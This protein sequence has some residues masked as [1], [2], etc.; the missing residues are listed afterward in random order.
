MKKSLNIL[1]LILTI[2]YKT[3]RVLLQFKHNDIH[4]QVFKTLNFKRKL[5]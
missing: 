5:G 3:V 4:I 2:F 1:Q